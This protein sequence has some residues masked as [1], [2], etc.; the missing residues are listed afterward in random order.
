MSENQITNQVTN[1]LGGTQ[2][3][4]P[5]N[6]VL[7]RRAADW[8]AGGHKVAL[9][10]VIQTWGSSPRPV[11]SVM[12]VRGDMEFAGSVSGGCVESA[13]ID[14]AMQS[15]ETGVGERLDFGVAD[16]TAWEVGL[17][18]GGQIAVLITPIM[19]AEQSGLS[20]AVLTKIAAGIDRRETVRICLDA[21]N[22]GLV[23]DAGDNAGDNDETG[24]Y[25]MGLDDRGERFVFV[26]HPPRRLI[27]VGAVH[28]SQFLAPIA[29]QTGFDVIVI[30]P[31]AAFT[32]GD[33]F[34]HMSG[35]TCRTGWPDNVMADVGLDANS[36]VV[37]LTH[38]PKIDDPGLQAALAHPVY[39]IAALGSRKTHAARCERLAAAGFSADD[40]ARIHGPAGLD[41]GAK[42]PAEIAISILGELI[43]A[44]RLAQ[45]IQ[46]TRNIQNTQNI[47]NTWGEKVKGR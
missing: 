8:Y 21:R 11:G 5:T 22:G 47:Q 28:I 34:G 19:A 44:E 1:Q 4:A 18:C 25:D 15:M 46:N 31:R 23:D 36:A 26:Q 12:V 6:D 39:H 38:D 35:V 20:G 2:N 27:I 40:I 9:A 43:A 24:L 32:G 16:T 42:T 37:T 45:N 13:V 41:I 33:R 30:D 14:A 10:I 3:H 17:S 7:L 29:A